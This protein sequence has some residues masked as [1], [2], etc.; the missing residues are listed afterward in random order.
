[1]C[2]RL[3]R[4]DEKAEILMV[5]R[6]RTSRTRTAGC[7]TMSEARSKKSRASWWRRKRRSAG[8]SAVDCRTR[9]EVVGISSEKKTVELKNHATGEVTTEKIRQTRAVARGGADPPAAARHRS[10]GNLS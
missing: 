10:S 5:E 6:D 7:R 1:V 8:S 4:L 2:A 3:R 9:C